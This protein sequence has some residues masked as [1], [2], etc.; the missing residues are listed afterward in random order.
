MCK[1]SRCST[2]IKDSARLSIPHW[3]LPEY[4]RSP[5][6]WWSWNKMTN[7]AVSASSG[8]IV[9]GKSF[10]DPF[11]GHWR[12]KA[13]QR[14]R[15]TTVYPHAKWPTP[16]SLHWTHFVSCFK[17][18][19]QITKVNKRNASRVNWAMSLYSQLDL[20][21]FSLLCLY[22]SL[23]SQDKIC[24]TNATCWFHNTATCPLWLLN[25]N[26][27]GLTWAWIDMY[28]RLTPPSLSF[29]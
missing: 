1:S 17:V 12:V 6:P 29:F 19:Y 10:V 16:G 25:H 8:I 18:V 22:A 27:D 24:N 7:N 15:V 28:W 9:S 4:Y 5:F 23:Q 3:V 11:W 26:I 2:L 20:H 14:S 13:V 21:T